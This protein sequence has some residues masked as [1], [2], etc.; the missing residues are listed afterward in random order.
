MN[1]DF[2]SRAIGLVQQVCSDCLPFEDYADLPTCCWWF[3]DSS[4]TLAVV[5]E[6]DAEK[7]IMC[8]VLA[9][10]LAW[11]GDRRL[12]LI[13]PAGHESKTMERVPWFTGSVDVYTY[14]ADDH[15]S[16]PVPVPTP[17]ATSA[18]AQHSK[19]RKVRPLRTHDLGTMTDQRDLGLESLF[20]VLEEMSGTLTRTGRITSE[21]WTCAGQK[22][23]VM[24]R[25]KKN[26]VTIT[27][28]VNYK[29]SLPAGEDRAL[30]RTATSDQPLERGDIEDIRAR[31]EHA[32]KRRLGA[33][34][35]YAEHRMQAN[36]FPSGLR[37]MGMTEVQREYPAYRS[38]NGGGFI[39]FL[40]LDAENRLHVIETKA[41][42][43]DPKLVLQALDYLLWVSANESEIRSTMQPHW[44]RT[45][46][47]LPVVVDFVCARRI[48][49]E[50]D[51]ADD[52]RLKAYGDAIGPYMAA[53]VE[54]LSDEVD[55]RIWLVDDL[56]TS[57]CRPERLQDDEIHESH[58]WIAKQIRSWP[59]RRP[60]A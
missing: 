30:L 50:G 38:G 12:V 18:V 47:I 16:E 56:T 43:N 25:T 52:Q 10:A 11:R 40:G 53:Q 39:D 36:M 3:A 24:Q 6:P 15:L 4:A 9:Y 14:G 49:S 7:S 29:R 59:P 42:P 44:N 54:A 5:V 20:Q 23:L 34:P 33:D 31:L 21:A 13:C 58:P 32:C 8:D 37:A 2:R 19:H 26:V 35:T 28:G 60:R 17:D 1:R 45:E 46:P 48:R 41:N 55:C 57:P 51:R 22:M 27:A